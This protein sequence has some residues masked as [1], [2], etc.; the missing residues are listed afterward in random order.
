VRLEDFG[1][2]EGESAAVLLANDDVQ[3]FVHSGFP[4]GG[5]ASGLPIIALPDAETAFHITGTEE[6]FV[7]MGDRECL[8]REFVLVLKQQTL[9]ESLR[10]SYLEA[11]GI[12]GY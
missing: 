1:V 11:T 10:Q 5:I 4:R 3:L 12:G 9:C 2:L 6:R 8:V 7:A